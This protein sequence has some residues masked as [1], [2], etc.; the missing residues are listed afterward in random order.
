M[1]D[2]LEQQLRPFRLRLTLRRSLEIVVVTVAI[3]LALAALIVGASRI[4]GFAAGP[5]LLAEVVAAAFLLV[6]LAYWRRPKTW[7]AALEVDSLGL[8]ER[9]TS[10]IHATQV[11][12]PAAT[13]VTMQALAALNAL[14][15]ASV[16]LRPTKRQLLVLGLATLAFGFALIGP[17]PRSRESALRAAQ[18]TAVAEARSSVDSVT[19]EVEAIAPAPV[20]RPVT[21]ELSKLERTLSRSTDVA[22]AGEEIERAQERIASLAGNEQF[23]ADRTLDELAAAWEPSPQ[24]KELA[25]ALQRRNA[26]SI[27]SALQKVDADLASAT[28]A[29]R[30]ALQLQL[31]VGANLARDLPQLAGA[32][33]DRAAASQNQT[34]ANQGSSNQI[35]SALAAA[36]S[37]SQTLNAAQT[38]LSGLSQARSA[39]IAN[40][41]VAAAGGA[42]AAGAAASAAGSGGAS[43]TGAGRGSGS[44]S[45]SGR[46]SGRGSG[47]GNGSGNGSGTGSGSGTGGGNGAGRGSG[48]GAGTGSSPGQPGGANATGSPG[49]SGV[50]PARDATTYETVF[51]PRLMGGQAGASVNV[52][53]QAKGASGQML[54]LPES[55]L[56]MG[57]LRPYNEV[58]ANYESAARRTLSR[59][60]LPPNLES[61]VRA[62]FGAIQPVR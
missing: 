14:D 39:M 48:S 44:G 25:G 19:A 35:A 59:S 7:Q 53:G 27:R 8:A 26:E 47:S 11:D 12:H 56:T 31:Q 57:R 10:A 2:A 1:K 54:E 15:P 46:G 21:E 9:A 32:L 50:A 17:L 23:A 45:G 36:A 51:A 58:F 28:Q 37:A 29:D 18:R 24:L 60:T 20:V 41:A 61:L 40:A 33:R 22:E 3:A 34:G 38:A 49:G 43:G 6:A 13:L 55:Q 5:F 62:Y 16:R 4:T 52:S 30:R 42:A